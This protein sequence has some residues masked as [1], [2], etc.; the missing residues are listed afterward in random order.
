[1]HHTLRRSPDG[2]GA[3]SKLQHALRALAAKHAGGGAAA[4]AVDGAGLATSPVRSDHCRPLCAGPLRTSR[5]AGGG[6][7]LGGHP[8]SL[9]HCAAASREGSFTKIWVTSNIYAATAAARGTSPAAKLTGPV[10][11][12]KRACQSLGSKHMAWQKRG[13]GVCLLLVGLG[14][15]GGG[16]CTCR[17]GWGWGRR[18][19]GVGAAGG[20]KHLLSVP[21]QQ[22]V[23]RGMA[24]HS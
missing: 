20:R 12:E 10:G 14:E 23:R 13:A 17:Q 15:W 11:S 3:V 8:K 24:P 2:A 22:M 18:G 21:G 19:R 9:L 6:V 5:H 1:M 7:G 16:G 4:P